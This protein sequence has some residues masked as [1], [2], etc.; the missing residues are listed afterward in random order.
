MFDSSRIYAIPSYWLQRL[1]SVSS[2]A[3]YLDSVLKAPST[4][5][6]TAIKWVKEETGETFI[7]IKVM[8]KWY[9][10]PKFS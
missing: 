4:L 7:R 2:G 9:Y 1:F 8:Y 6:A 5:V 3:L 10:A